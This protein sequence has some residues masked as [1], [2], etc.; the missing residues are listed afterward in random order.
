MKIRTMVLS[1]LAGV[2]VLS[3]WYKG[4]QTAFIAFGSPSDSRAESEADKGF[5]KIGIVNIGKIFQDSKRMARYRRE[6]LVEQ[7]KTEAELKSLE[8]KIDADKE[9]LKTLKPGS[10]DY[11]ALVEEMFEKQ[12][13]QEAQQE[14]QKLRRALKEK[15]IVEELYEAILRETAEVAKQEGL[16][17]VFEKSEPE[18]PAPSLTQLELAIA[19][20]KV[21]YSSGLCRDITDKVMARVDS[22]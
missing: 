18:I 17:L 19:V 22:K 14:F 15:R 16:D 6:A 11:L 13:K 9:G 2:V 12:G 7:Q 20:H 10:S 5:L 8:K 1:C 21:L 3:M 4:G